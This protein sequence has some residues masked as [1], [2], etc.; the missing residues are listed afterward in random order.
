MSE[1]DEL[2]VVTGGSKGIGRSIVE[3]LAA[4]GR[5]VVNLDLREPDYEQPARHLRTDL[6]DPA[7]IERAFAEIA[8]LGRVVGLV[9][10]AGFAISKPLAQSCPEDYERLVPLNV[11][12]P[13]LCARHAAASM[14]EAGWGRIVNISSRAALGKANRT[15]YAATKGAVTAMA[16]VWAL[17]LAP[18]NI[19]VNVV[20]PGPIATDLFLEVNPE[21]SPQSRALAAAIPLGRIGSPADVAAAVS[22][23]LSRASGFVTG[24]V[25]YVCGGLTV[26][27]QA[28]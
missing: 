15:A 26:G 25:L 7:A 27:A 2:V 14:R 24:Q 12:G 11:V 3:G 9:N 1:N 21:D 23:F 19:T 10:N 20:G 5:P 18:H 6:T 4:E 8:A 17:E 28:L 13:A 16:R 22:F